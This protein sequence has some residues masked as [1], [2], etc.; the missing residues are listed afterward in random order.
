M[1]NWV[2]LIVVLVLALFVWTGYRKGFIRQA[3]DLALLVVSIFITFAFY[4][5]LGSFLANHFHISLLSGVLGKMVALAVLWFGTQLIFLFLWRIFYHQLPE[6]LRESGVNKWF[7]ALPGLL[8]GVIFIAVVLVLATFILGLFPNYKNYHDALADSVSGKLIVSNSGWFQKQ[9]LS[10]LGG[11]LGGSVIFKTVEPNSDTV[12]DLGFKTLN[13]KIDPVAENK[14]L[15]LVNQDRAAKGLSSLV[16]DEKL[17]AVAEAHA[18]DMFAKGYFAHNGKDGKTPF[19]RL[20]DAGVK[21]MVAGENLALAPDVNA[22]EQGLM[23]SPGHR[24]NILAPEYT[25]VGIGVL[26]AGKYGMIFVQE[27]T[28]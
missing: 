4:G 20:D 22:A 9:V 23:N 18:R 25:K 11:E 10:P 5:A 17:K 27:F 6:G 1:P 14:M 15:E 26:S 7:G 21:Y 24:A 28:N 8:W 2:D 16:M 13:V 3:G 19:Q 12:Y